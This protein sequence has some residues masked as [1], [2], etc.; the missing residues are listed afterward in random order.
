MNQK[1]VLSA[2][3]FFLYNFQFL[4]QVYDLY[5]LKE[6]SIIPI[7]FAIPNS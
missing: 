6:S 2:F 4:I 7:D 1:L 5:A 3:S